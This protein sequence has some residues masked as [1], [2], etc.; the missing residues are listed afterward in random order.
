MVPEGAAHVIFVD[1]LVVIATVATG[2]LAGHVVAGGFTGYVQAVGVHIGDI[3]IFEFIVG[4]AGG[5]VGQR[6]AKT[7]HIL[8]P[9][10]HIQGRPGDRIGALFLAIGT[11]G[12]C[13][14][15][16]VESFPA[17]LKHANIVGIP[18]IIDIGPDEGGWVNYLTGRTAVRGE[19]RAR[20]SSDNGQNKAGGRVISSVGDARNESSGDSK[21]D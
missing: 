11:G 3:G 13:M 8:V 4:R 17:I 18:G 12:E 2:K 15:I 6:V 9:R 1:V 14:A 16:D 21:D 19:D 5:F 10:R 7:E 20:R